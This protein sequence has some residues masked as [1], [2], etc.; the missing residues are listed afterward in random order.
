MS[1]T[2]TTTT[3]A[4]A[5]KRLTCQAEYHWYC[6]GEV[7]PYTVV[8]K[9]EPRKQHH[10]ADKD[11]QVNMCKLHHDW[12]MKKGDHVN[13]S[14]GLLEM[15][16]QFEEEAIYENLFQTTFANKHEEVSNIF[17][18]LVSETDDDEEEEDADADAGATSTQKKEWFL[19]NDKHIE[20]FKKMLFK[21]SKTRVREIGTFHFDGFFVYELN[22]IIYDNDID[23]MADLLNY[24]SPIPDG[25][26][27]K[28]PIKG[29]FVTQ[30]KA[31]KE[32]YPAMETEFKLT[33]LP[34]VVTDYFKTKKRETKFNEFIEC[35]EFIEANIDTN[36]INWKEIHQMSN[37][38]LF[39]NVNCVVNALLDDT[40]KTTID[41]S[42]TPEVL[43][44]VYVMAN[45]VFYSQNERK[46]LRTNM[47]L[48]ELFIYRNLEKQ[49]LALAI[50][51]ERERNLGNKQHE[52]HDI[53][54][55]NEFVVKTL[56]PRQIMPS[57][58]IYTETDG[59]RFTPLEYWHYF[60]NKTYSIGFHTIVR[61]F[62]KN[63]AIRVY[64]EGFN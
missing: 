40:K 25:E 26:F 22:E 62:E 59:Q 5:A 63:E 55:E 2:T 37:E 61:E 10:Q 58:H 35:I 44:V 24:Y 31:R 48:I 4:A 13:K 8:Y 46:R 42:V 32:P 20:H 56:V 45:H 9:C 7:K 36:I 52:H 54:Y 21:E 15:T 18:I 16:G 3:T 28:K 11:V 64:L 53:L 17:T 47:F 1:S 34:S 38:E 19:L 23:A 33:T 30:W 49:L 43:W 39:Y 41:V 51:G 6:T 14:T 12:L 60:S 29:G 50:S 57:E 27:I